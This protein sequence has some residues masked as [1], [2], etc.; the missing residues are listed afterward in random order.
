MPRVCHISSPISC[1]DIMANGSPNV[2][3]Q[4]QLTTRISVDNTQSHCFNPTPIAVGSPNVFVNNIP[5]AR[6]GDPIVPH[7]CPGA[8]CHGGVVADG[9]NNVII[10]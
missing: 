7:C 1:G 4:N 6:V 9:P 8:G 5:V 2:I 10:N 3:S